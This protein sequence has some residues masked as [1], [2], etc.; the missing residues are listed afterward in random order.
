MSARARA[1]ECNIFAELCCT[2][3]GR[4]KLWQL[5]SSYR[6]AVLNCRRQQCALATSRVMECADFR[7]EWHI[8]SNSNLS[9]PQHSILLL[10]RA[11]C[12]QT[13]RARKQSRTQSTAPPTRCALC[14]K[15]AHSKAGKTFVIYCSSTLP[16]GVLYLFLTHSLMSLL[17]SSDTRNVFKILCRARRARASGRKASI[18]NFI[19][20]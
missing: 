3:L 19:I 14:E 16:R 17:C 11:K 7:K 15:C 12:M 1:C 2:A 20:N 9:L 13:R 10:E 8:H 6:C 4:T 18:V 5:A